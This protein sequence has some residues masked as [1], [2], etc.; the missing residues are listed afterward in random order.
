[1][2]NV[3]FTLELSIG[4][5]NEDSNK[6]FSLNNFVIVIGDRYGW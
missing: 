2:Q 4:W 3:I 6:V 5:L 1:M